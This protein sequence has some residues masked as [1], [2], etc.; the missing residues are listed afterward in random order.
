MNTTPISQIVWLSNTQCTPQFK[1]HLDSVAKVLGVE[2]TI[3]QGEGVL[4]PTYQAAFKRFYENQNGTFNED[5]D[6]GHDQEVQKSQES[7]E[8]HTN[9]SNQDE[10]ISWLST[11]IKQKKRKQM[12]DNSLNSNTDY[13]KG[14]RKKGPRRDVLS[15]TPRIGGPKKAG[16]FFLLEDSPVKG[17]KDLL[18]RKHQSGGAMLTRSQTNNTDRNEVLERSTDVGKRRKKTTKNVLEENPT[19]TQNEKKTEAE[20]ETGTE[21]EQKTETVVEDDYD[22]K[23]S[24]FDLQRGAVIV[25][26]DAF[27][28]DSR[29]DS[30]KL[31][32]DI[33]NDSLLRT[34]KHLNLICEAGSH[35][36]GINLVVISQSPVAVT[37]SSI[38]ANLVRRIRQ[39]IDVFYIFKMDSNT[40]RHFVNTISSGE[41]YQRIKSIMND[42]TN[43]PSCS[44]IDPLD[45]R[46][47]FPAFE[48]TLSNHLTFLLL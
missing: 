25:V 19:E 17:S 27:L 7:D 13:L 48:F 45:Q 34:L 40:A 16:K 18:L 30:A 28:T 12:S 9:D 5:S 43:P 33:Q 20:T 23:K 36:C 41:T 24:E 10:C 35:H 32:S 1:E 39:N 42:A 2:A 31:N 46:G 14:L 47:C 6:L 37:G 21:T 15:S 11:V 29:K 22:S 44:T 4:H 26:D 8:T 38:L 3:F